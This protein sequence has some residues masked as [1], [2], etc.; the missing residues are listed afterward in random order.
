MSH[1]SEFKIFLEYRLLR[2]IYD[3]ENFFLELS[4]AYGFQ[5][6]KIGAVPQFFGNFGTFSRF[7]SAPATYPRQLP[8]N[9]L[10][11]RATNSVTGV[12][13]KAPAAAGNKFAHRK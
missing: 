8:A 13:H 5:S 12:A 7:S 11:R 2:D 3:A 4:D 6:T 1:R 9:A 10:A